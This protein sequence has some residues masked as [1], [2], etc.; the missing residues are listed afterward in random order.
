MVWVY[1]FLTDEHLTARM[2]ATLQ[3]LSRYYTGGN[4]FF[5][6]IASDDKT[7][8]HF[9]TPESKHASKVRKKK[10][11]H[12]ESAKKFRTWIQSWRW[13][14]GIVLSSLVTFPKLHLLT[15]S[16]GSRT[17]VWMSTFVCTSSHSQLAESP[18]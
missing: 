7:W 5:E 6:R 11:K 14:F 8:E 15:L 17:R 9:R 13:T 12:Q 1:W 2:S 18:D 4:G 3:F 10:K 16:H